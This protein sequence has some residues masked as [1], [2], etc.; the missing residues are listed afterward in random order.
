VINYVLIAITLNDTTTA[1]STF[2]SA[3]ITTL[4]NLTF[5][6]TI[7]NVKGL[8]SKPDRMTETIIP[9]STYPPNEEPLTL[10]DFFKD[11]CRI[12]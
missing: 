8:T 5:Q 9:V 10:K 6:L 1:N 11:I 3:V 12:R 7:P 2:T 4:I